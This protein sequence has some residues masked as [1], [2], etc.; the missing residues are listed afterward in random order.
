MCWEGVLLTA[1]RLELRGVKAR[2]VTGVP[3]KRA[4]NSSLVR[5]VCAVSPN[6]MLLLLEDKARWA[7]A[8]CRLRCWMRLML[9]D[10]TEKRCV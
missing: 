6:R 9:S 3:R 10:Q 4:L 2:G 7:A 8:R 1:V 5:S